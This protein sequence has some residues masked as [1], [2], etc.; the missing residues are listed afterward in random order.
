MDSARLGLKGETWFL[1]RSFMELQKDVLTGSREMMI[2][3]L[4]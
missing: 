2:F 4:L 3:R 1:M